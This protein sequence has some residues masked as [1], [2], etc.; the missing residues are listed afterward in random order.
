M[1]R[2]DA[3]PGGPGRGGR[4]FRLC[5]RGAG[6]ATL[7]VLLVWAFAWIARRGGPEYFGTPEALLPP[8]TGGVATWRNF[9]GFLQE[10]GRLKAV[11][12]IRR[13]EELAALLLSDAKWR[14]LQRETDKAHYAILNR[15]ARNFIETCFGREVTLALVPPPKGDPSARSGLLVVAR[16][17]AGLEENLA[18]LVLHFYPEL[19]LESRSYR[20]HRIY[21]YSAEKTRRAFS[22]C[23]FGKTVVVSL[24][25]A[26]W[27]WLEEVIDRKI[28]KAAVGGGDGDGSR[29]AS[30]ARDPAFLDSA[31][32]RGTG[33]GLSVFVAPQYAIQAL[34][35][36]P[37]KI[38]RSPRWAFWLDY[39]AEKL[40][41]T[42]W[43][44]LNLRLEDGRRSGG[45][46]RR[47]GGGG[48]RA[49][50]FWRFTTPRE[51]GFSRRTV[52]PELLRDLPADTAALL[53]L[54]A[55]GLGSALRELYARMANSQAYEGRVVR[56]ARNWERETGL[57]FS[58][59]FLDSAGRCVGAALTG[60]RWTGNALFPA[61]MVRGWWD[62][63]HSEKALRLQALL[64]AHTGGADRPL[65]LKPGALTF[66]AEERWLLLNLNETLAPLGGADESD[67]SATGLSSHP[68]LAQVWS[69]ES[70]SEPVLCL[71][72]DFEGTYMHLR[73]L[74]AVASTGSTVA[75]I[76]PSKVRRDVRRWE[77]I[78]AAVRHL[79]S[80]RLTVEEG[81][82]GVTGEL[83]LAVE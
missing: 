60:F 12:R 32:R 80:L 81:R 58:E 78:L 64:A 24:R 79:R 72:A 73:R 9:S 14:E 71:F 62:A 20:G 3:D 7:G 48:L 25:S 74:H 23:R 66:R 16:T 83:L 31:N 61:P 77:T 51:A 34:R 21:R 70:E 11:E 35:S 40:S 44:A 82:E 53:V 76:W 52:V 46:G 39:A 49:E 2:S 27:H 30:L 13:D 50:S 55:Q 5:A 26:D 56:F 36:A 10:V 65:A 33:D 69:Q 47:G 1:A 18:E 75:S 43:A 17:D 8:E 45:D 41:D 57:R 28:G 54:E 22:Y 4:L 38:S 15:A 63:G 42:N 59:D 19:A 6:A 67:A 29:T 68:L 37:G